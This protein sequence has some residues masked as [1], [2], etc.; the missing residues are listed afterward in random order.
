MWRVVGRGGGP[1]ARA[2]ATN[3]MV[4]SGHTKPTKHPDPRQHPVSE[5]AGGLV[6]LCKLL[7]M[8]LLQV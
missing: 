3:P 7:E 1:L 8:F 5:R 6:A 2:F 4:A